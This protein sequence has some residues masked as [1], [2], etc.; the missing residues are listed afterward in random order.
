MT[1]EAYEKRVVLFL[2][3]LGFKELIKKGREIELLDVLSIPQDLVGK[4]PFDGS[5]KMEITAFSDSIVVSELVESDFNIRRM[6]GYAS[7]LFTKFLEKKILIR[8]GIALGNLHHKDGIVFGPALVEAYKLESELAFYP[9]IAVTDEIARSTL[10]GILEHHNEFAAIFLGCLRR[11]FDG[12]IH[13]NTFG[14][15]GHLPAIGLPPKP[16]PEPGHGVSYEQHEIAQA[17][18]YLISEV[19]RERPHDSPRIAAKY[20]WLQRYFD[21]RHLGQDWFN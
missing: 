10:S 6:V 1:Q 3:I 2:D 4:Y 7:Y 20:D 19:M 8:G 14:P 18:A 16:T 11:D 13:V 17:Y 21:N 9:R 12:V 5:T 15:F